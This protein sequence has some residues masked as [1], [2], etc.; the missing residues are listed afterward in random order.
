MIRKKFL[1][2]FDIDGTLILTGKAG[3]ASL[4]RAVEEC[5]GVPKNQVR[6]VMAGATDSSIAMELLEKNGIPPTPENVTAL[7]DTYLGLLESALPASQGTVLPGMLQFLEILRDRPD[8][9]IGLLTG[10]IRRGAELKLSHF[11]VWEFFEFGAFADDH[12]DRNEL[13][14]VAAGRAAEVHGDPF[15]PERIFVI[16]DTPKDIACGR[17]IGA[18]TVAVATGSYPAAELR[19]HHPDFLFEDFSDPAGAVA[20]LLEHTETAALPG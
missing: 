17:V 2:L 19:Q 9:A 15:P 5:F 6:V 13:G 1:F 18:K 11:G 14:P 8:C 10:N 4:Y 7:L 12:H 20:K 3:E 16:G